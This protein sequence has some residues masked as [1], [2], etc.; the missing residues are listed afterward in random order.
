VTA[1]PLQHSAQAG[2]LARDLTD[3]LEVRAHNGRDAY[4]YVETLFARIVSVLRRD[5]RFAG[6]SLF[7]LELMFADARREAENILF[8]A[9][10]GRLHL[11]DARDAVERCLPDAED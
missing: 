8:H 7:E 5:P 2:R 10:C 11:D 4:H 6:I 3:L 1:M 9:M